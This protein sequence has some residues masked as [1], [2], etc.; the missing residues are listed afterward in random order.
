MS[1]IEKPELGI[2]ISKIKT[3]SFI[4]NDFGLESMDLIRMDFKHGL[5][6]RLSDNFIVFTLMTTFFVV[7]GDNQQMVLDCAIQ[8]FFEVENLKQYANEKELKLDLPPAITIAIVSLSVS[9]ARAIISNFT[10]GTNLQDFILPIIDP[11]KLA[12]IFFP[13]KNVT[14][15]EGKNNFEDI[16]LAP[17]TNSQKSK[18]K[19]AT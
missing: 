19:K 5:N 7:N 17:N 16:E 1:L 18:S 15:V 13:E 2:K 4:I 9:H 14:M 11:V 12:T 6:L 10:N 3:L 8:N